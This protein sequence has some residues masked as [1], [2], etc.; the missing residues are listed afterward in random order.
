MS[1]SSDDV[2]Q[3]DHSEYHLLLLLFQK[4]KYHTHLAVLYLEEVLRLRSDPATSI[5]ALN[6]K[7]LA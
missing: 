2:Y 7:R 6:K 4:E 1:S 3:N 5:E